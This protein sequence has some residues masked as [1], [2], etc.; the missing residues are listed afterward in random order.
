MV[1]QKT[2]KKRLRKSIR[3]ISDYCRNNRHKPIKVQHYKLSLKMRGHYSYFG[4]TGNYRA[5][6]KFYTLC[7]CAWKKWLSRRNNRGV[8][9]ERYE[10]ILIC[11]PLPTPRIVHSINLSPLSRQKSWGLKVHICRHVEAAVT[12]GARRATGVTAAAANRSPPSQFT[13]PGVTASL[14]GRHIRPGQ[15][16]SAGV[17]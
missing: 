3:K 15:Y 2:Q 6:S 7:R 11:Y 12:E 10:Q 13:S 14:L 16:T 4:I 17:R 5:L 9:W 8:T 1:K